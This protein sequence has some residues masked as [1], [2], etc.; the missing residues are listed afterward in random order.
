MP[1]GLFSFWRQELVDKNTKIR[2]KIIEV[3]ER[4]STLELRN[5]SNIGLAVENTPPKPYF[6][7]E[8]A[9]ARI[10][11]PRNITLMRLEKF[12]SSLGCPNSCQ[13]PHPSGL[14]VIYKGKLKDMMDV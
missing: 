13:T 12:Y 8:C 4:I 9:M 7:V 2:N 10:T 14:E 1:Q 6:L 3:E 11:A 5:I